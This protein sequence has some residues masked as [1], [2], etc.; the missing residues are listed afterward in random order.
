[1]VIAIG[2]QIL[3]SLMTLIK[4]SLRYI[5]ITAISKLTLENFPKRKKATTL[6]GIDINH[7]IRNSSF[8]N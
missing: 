7:L 4:E 3:H 5:K 8:Y 2:N 6:L 1:M